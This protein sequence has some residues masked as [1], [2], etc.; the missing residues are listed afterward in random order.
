MPSNWRAF[1]A[2]ELHTPQ[3]FAPAPASLRQRKKERECMLKKKVRNKEPAPAFS[4]SHFWAR[5]KSGTGQPLS[6][7]PSFFY[8]R[9]G[10]GDG[11]APLGFLRATT[12]AYRRVPSERALRRGPPLPD[13]AEWR[14]ASQAGLFPIARHYPAS[15][16]SY[17]RIGPASSVMASTTSG[18]RL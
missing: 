14:C 17:C 10:G 2:R 11:T 13:G 5:L 18:G 12:G 3:G 8:P 7:Q 15:T 9:G 1:A 16:A 6:L 4:S